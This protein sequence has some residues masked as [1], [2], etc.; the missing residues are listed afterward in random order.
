MLCNVLDLTT[1]DACRKVPP[2]N[3]AAISHISLLTL[4]TAAYESAWREST[5]VPGFEYVPGK[6]HVT[7]EAYKALCE[8]MNEAASMQASA[9]D[10]LA[11]HVGADVANAIVG[12]LIQAA[13]R[14]TGTRR[15][16]FPVS[17]TTEFIKDCIRGEAGV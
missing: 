17:D 6:G 11:A 3:A 8:R 10:G 13:G 9:R 15:P 7:T 5:E 1:F 12:A 16:D 14:T 4:A 2:M